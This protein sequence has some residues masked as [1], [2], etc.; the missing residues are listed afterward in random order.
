MKKLSLVLMLFFCAVGTMLAQR[1]ITGV[2]T[3]DKGEALI[4]ASVIVKGAEGIGTT[5]DIDGSFSLEV[6]AGYDVLVFSYTGYGT[7]EETLGVSNVINVSLIEGITVS[8]VVV[9]A[10]GIKRDE[11][12]LGYAVSQVNGDAIQKAGN[13]S[14]LDALN[15]KVAGATITSSGGN[16]GSGTS[17]IIR[18]FS[19]ITGS[20][21]PLYVVDGIPVSN[22]ETFSTDDGETAYGAIKGAN[23]AVDINPDDIAS[24]TVLKGG[25]A[26]ALYGIDA[27]NGAVIITTKSGTNAKK[28]LGVEYS[29][30][31]GTSTYNRLPE[32]THDFARGRG[33]AYS[34]VTHWSW[35]AAYASN[36]TFPAGTMVDLNGDGTI[37]DEGGNPIPLYKDNYKRF[38]QTG[39][40][41]KHNI[42]FTGKNDNGNMIASFSRH[43][44]DGIVPNEEYH[45]TSALVRGSQKIS[46]RLT[47]GVKANFINSGGKRFQLARGISQGLGYWHHMWDIENYGWKAPD[48]SKTWFSTGVVA[49]QWVVNEEGEDYSV[50]RI[51]GSIDLDFEINSWLSATYRIGLD[52]FADKRKEVR[53]FS[54]VETPNDAG[55][56]TEISIGNTLLNSDLML[57]G[58]FDLSDDLDLTVL[59]GQNVR[60]EDYNR[61]YVRG[62]SL[63][64]KNFDD[65]TN[66]SDQ[67][68]VKRDIEELRYGF[69]SEVNLGYKNFLYLGITARNDWS[70][71]LPVDNNSFFYP[72]VNLGFIFSELMDNNNILS[73]GKLRASWSSVANAPKPQS[74]T[75]VYI[76][77]NPKVGGILRYEQTD[78]QNNPTL[79]PEASKEFEIGTDL[80]FWQNKIGFDIAYYKKRSI[81]QTLSL[82]LSATTGRTSYKTN[83]GEIENS[84]IEAVLSLNDLLTT[85]DLHWGLSFNYSKNK[86]KIVK[87]ADGLDQI[88]LRNGWWTNTQLIAAEGEAWGT[89]YGYAYERNDAGQLLIDANG[90]PIQT[91][92]RQ[93][94]GNINPDWILGIVP[95]LSWKGLSLNATLEYKKGGDVVNGSEA[96]FIYAGLSATTAD[97]YYSATDPYAHAT[98]VFEGVREVSEGVYETNTIAAPLT[99]Q[100]YQQNY[101]NVDENIV[102]DAT[103]W[104]L[105]NVSLNYDLPEAWIGSFSNGISLNLTFINPWLKTNFKGIDPE[106]SALG[107]N[108]PGFNE[109]ASPNTKSIIFGAKVKF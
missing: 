1:T 76:P 31:Y 33:G 88:I 42:T 27:A 81:D 66:T 48:G 99:N 82:P 18:G 53:P 55:D 16:A 49:P 52:N 96:N 25:A 13:V 5:S 3:D 51:I 29:Y 37:T 98:R 93:I 91:A 86:G 103:W 97:R 57:R 95:N 67:V 21:Q 26:A 62:D 23:R 75:D 2:L 15:G 101:I 43:N 35:G 90:Y 17:V 8:E 78:S 9:T 84:G 89:I 74:L 107:V 39:G 68:V 104:R 11:K 36:P 102:E 19:S 83:I 56:I 6:P 92:E 10:L 4:G 46:D 100:F 85:G 71:T 72:S 58:K 108:Y 41:Q 7:K 80:K 94:I 64:L 63:V 12:T 59:L 38:W 20:N 77:V 73:Y 61:L 14:A 50:N 65:V 24:V 40:I 28:G 106:V 34:N 70:S 69:Y 47:L 30:S 54:S 60:H 109:L 22:D 105:R 79:R 44:Q 32:F 87:L 45:R